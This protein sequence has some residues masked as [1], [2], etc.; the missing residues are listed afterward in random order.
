M[1][2][3]YVCVGSRELRKT[4]VCEI[5]SEILMQEYQM[6]L[7]TETASPEKVID[8]AKE[9]VNMGL[10]FL[11][12]ELDCGMTGLDLAGEIRKID[13]R[14][15]IVFLASYSEMISLTFQY[16]TEALGFIR[17]NDRQQMQR[18]IREYLAYT[19]QIYSQ[20]KRGSC[21]TILIHKCRKKLALEYREILFFETSSDAHKLIVHMHEENIEFFGKMKDIENEVGKDFIRCHRGYLVN[22]NYIQSIDYEHRDI[23]LKTKERCPVSQRMIGRLKNLI[24]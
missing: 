15:F 7:R 21:K 14:G 5:Q 3:V 23:I 18:L 17:K 16:K 6:K 9:S 12:M 13:S 2:D 10:Y 1:L 4:T 24:G 20:M 8:A 19:W 22:K 11:D